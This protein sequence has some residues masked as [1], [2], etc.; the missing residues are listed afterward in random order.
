[1]SIL[2]EDRAVPEVVS[3]ALDRYRQYGSAL[4]GSAVSCVFWIA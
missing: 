2:E 1:M 3:L 4:E